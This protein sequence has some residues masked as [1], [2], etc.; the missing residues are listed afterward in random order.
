MHVLIKGLWSIYSHN[1]LINSDRG[2]LGRMVD[3]ELARGFT[4]IGGHLDR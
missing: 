2:R 4:E 3:D 1:P